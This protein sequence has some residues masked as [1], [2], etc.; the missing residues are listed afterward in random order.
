MYVVMKIV[1]TGG[2]HNSA[3][4]LAK[5]CKQHHGADVVWYGHKYTSL[6][7]SNISAEYTEVTQAGIPFRYL[8]SGKVYRS[9]NPL[10]WLRVPFGFVQALFFLMQDKPDVIVSFGGY[11]AVPVVVAGW[12]LRIPSVTHEQTV[13]TGLA[14]AVIAKF[15]RK[16]CITWKSSAAHFPSSKVEHVGLPLRK[17]IFQSTSSAFVFDNADPTLFV[18][19]GKQGSHIINRALSEDMETLLSKYNVI[20]QCGAHSRFR[21]DLALGRQRARLPEELQKKYIIRS[22]VYEDEIGEAF[23]R[24]DVV[25]S[26]AGAHTAYELAALGK[27]AIMIP[28]PWVSRQEQLRNAQVLEEVGLVDILP[29]E[30]LSGAQLLKALDTMIS[31][32]D[33]HRA[34]GT[35]S[36]ALIREDAI[37]LMVGVIRDVVG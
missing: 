23:Q 24:A 30:E 14:N 37:A 29:E 32:L 19:A 36:K 13:V 10:H 28:I 2:H 9:F 31:S 11:L 33:E 27:P 4:A 7:D 8:K 1:F 22:Y 16:I 35:K 3:L 25:V 6:Y 21:D 34:A 20:H 18:T 17:S 5:E 15:A 12:I 26:R